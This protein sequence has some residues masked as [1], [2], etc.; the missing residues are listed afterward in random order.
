MKL[1]H[2]SDLHFGSSCFVPEWA[3]RVICLIQREA[4]DVLVVAGDLTENGFEEEYKEAMF[5]FQGLPMPKV[6][7]P[8][9][10]DVRNGGDVIFEE[11]F[12]SRFKTFTSNGTSNGW[13]IVGID[14]SEPD[15]DD[16]H[17]G[18]ENYPWIREQ[19]QG[20]R[21]EVTILV[22]HHHL[23]PIPATGRERHIP[24]DAGDLLKVIADL[25]LTFV[26]SGHKHRPWTWVLE[27]TCFVTSGTATTKRLKGRSFP[28]FNVIQCQEGLCEVIEVN[29][30]DG[31]R[32]KVRE[33]KK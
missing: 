12:G 27:K 10:H 7:V 13:I 16:G 25:E 3:Q 18:R 5:F 19:F 31:S 21:G 8:G 28:S 2:L 32:N 1:V 26:L 23:I 14:S 11:V 24:V 22:M 33:I 4:P 29:V 30:K 15:I 17:V 6:I 9:N 20:V